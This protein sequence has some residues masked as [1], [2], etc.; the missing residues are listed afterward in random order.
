MS[1]GIQGRVDSS[2]TTEQRD[3]FASGIVAEIGVSAYAVWHAIKFYADYN[4][5]KAFPGMRTISAKLGISVGSVSNAI[6][7]L[8]AAK[9]LRIAQGHT[10]RRGQT[11]IAR[12]R[13]SVNIGTTT[14]CTIV[15][16][17]VPE[18]L[19]GQIKRIGEALR[20]GE[21]DPEAFA[22]VEIIPGP[23]FEW[24]PVA[25]VLRGKLAAASLPPANT[26]AD[27]YH[28]QLGEAFIARIM[29]PKKALKK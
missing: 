3:L 23:G 25:K 12:E 2:F 13:M 29:A 11:Y 10:K 6:K 15:I 26:D 9:M 19:R 27:D 8:E 17:Y 14:L 18:R 24:D 21:D 5:G 7:A 28:K 20:T 16:D 1:N 4:T 22:E